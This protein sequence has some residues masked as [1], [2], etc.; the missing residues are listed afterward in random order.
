MIPC[1]GHRWRR[2]SQKAE[3]RMFLLGWESEEV[4]VLTDHWKWWMIQLPPLLSCLCLSLDS[5]L[6]IK[7]PSDDYR[8][9]RSQ[10]ERWRRVVSN[11]S[12]LPKIWQQFGHFECKMRRK[13]ASERQ[14]QTCEMSWL[15]GG[16]CLLLP[17]PA[18]V[19]AEEEE[20]EADTVNIH[21]NGSLSFSRSSK[22][23]FPVG[24]FWL[25]LRQFKMGRRRGKRRWSQQKQ[26][27]QQ[28]LAAIL[29]H[30][31]NLVGKGMGSKIR[32]KIAGYDPKI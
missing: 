20:E 25:F 2:P 24:L 23:V 9:C 4:Y 31:F 19:V 26:Q 5:Y 12:H 1:S 13:V 32:K 14:Q 28:Q 8:C 6:D 27:Q 30:D 15:V 22:S 11:I 21:F 10:R 29:T 16:W 18:A 17:L 7:L 3:K